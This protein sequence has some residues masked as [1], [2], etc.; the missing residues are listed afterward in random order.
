M[1]LID[2]DGPIVLYWHK[3][4]LMTIE[5]VLWIFWDVFRGALS[6]CQYY[7]A[8]MY[9]KLINNSGRERNKLEQWSDKKIDYLWFTS[10]RRDM[11]IEDRYL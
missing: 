6:I 9:V 5:M 11:W 3:S 8:R 10:L 4:K 1:S 2:K 7:I